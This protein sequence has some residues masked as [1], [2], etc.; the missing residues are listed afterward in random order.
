[1][2]FDGVLGSC[3]VLFCGFGDS[4]VSLRSADACADVFGFAVCGTGCSSLGV[5]SSAC[6]LVGVLAALDVPGVLGVLGASVDGGVWSRNFLG[7]N[8]AP[9][10][11]M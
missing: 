3:S 11:S 2:A 5:L 6:A 4:A 8:S 10:F 7:V 9:V 1:M